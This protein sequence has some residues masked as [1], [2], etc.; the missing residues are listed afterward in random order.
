M[1]NDPLK[2]RKL[3]RSLGVET[4]DKIDLYNIAKYMAGKYNGRVCCFYIIDDNTEIGEFLADIIN[5]TTD[6]AKHRVT[7]L[8]PK[9][10]LERFQD[11]RP[12]VVI[13]DYHMDRFGIDGDMVIIRMREMEKAS[14]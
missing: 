11:E 8:D 5:K 12:D 9:A 14:K 1:S 7:Y 3:G 10:A 4:F 6:N 2:I 13:T